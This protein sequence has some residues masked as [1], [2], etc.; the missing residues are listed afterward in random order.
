MKKIVRVS[1]DVTYEDGTTENSTL[2]G[3]SLDP[4]CGSIG[5]GHK[6]RMAGLDPRGQVYALDVSLT[7]KECTYR[8]SEP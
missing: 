1:V 3:S 5:L 6:T 7:G 4:I 2:I 8:S